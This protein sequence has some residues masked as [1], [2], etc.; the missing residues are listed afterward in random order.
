MNGGIAGKVAQKRFP[1][2]FREPFQRDLIALFEET[3]TRAFQAGVGKISFRNA[4]TI[5]TKPDDSVVMH[6][7]WSETTL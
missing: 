5:T 7:R 4:A 3:G 2:G 1:L 6:F